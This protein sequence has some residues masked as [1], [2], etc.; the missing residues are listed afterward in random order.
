M[1]AFGFGLSWTLNLMINATQEDDRPTLN[2]QLVV[3]ENAG[4]QLKIQASA[5]GLRAQD[6]LQVLVYGQRQAG[7]GADPGGRDPEGDDRDV[8]QAACR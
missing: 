8:A 7:Q 6:R 1:V 4:W 5:S 3:D 2:G